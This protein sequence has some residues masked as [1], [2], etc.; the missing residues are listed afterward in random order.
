MDPISAWFGA[1]QRLPAEM[2]MFRRPDEFT[3]VGMCIGTC[4]GAVVEHREID[5][6]KANCRAAEV[7]RM[8]RQGRR[9]TATS[10]AAGYGNARG[11][12]A[13]FSCVIREPAQA[14]V[15]IVE[16]TVPRGFWREPV[17]NRDDDAIKHQRRGAIG[18]IAHISVAEDIASAVNFEYRRA[19]RGGAPGR[20]VGRRGK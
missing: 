11:V 14:C 4:G 17:V 8:Q 15:V 13:Q 16:R 19:Q 18:R 5:Q 3:G 12:D 20:S 9:M 1:H 7:A 2:I 6:L 10:A